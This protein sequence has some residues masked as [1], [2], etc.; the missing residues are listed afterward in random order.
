MLKKSSMSLY[1][2]LFI[3]L[4]A[5][6]FP[7]MAAE[8]KI[9][10]LALRGAN[11]TQSH[12][13]ILADTLNESLP[14]EH[15]TLQP[16]NLDEMRD[17]IAER[18]ID[19]LLTNPAQFI[20]LDSRYHLRWL[21]SLRSSVEPDSATRNVIGSLILVRAD[22]DINEVKNLIGKKVGAISPDAFGGYLLSYKV[23]RDMGYDAEK[24]FRMQFLGFPADALL[25]ALRDSSLSAAII[26][27]CLLENMDSEGL[28]D[29]NQFRPLIEHA[30]T[31]PCKTSTELY[32]NWSFAA[33]N[34]VP[35]N[36]VDK[37]T[38]TLLS[39]D[40]SGMR[41]G[42]P[43]SV[44]QVETLL[45]DVNQHPQ[46]RQIWQDIMSWLIQHQLSLGL[47]LLFFILLGVNHV[48]IAFLVRRRSRQLEEAH[49]RLRQQEA[50][51]EKAQRLNI[52]GEMASGF[53]HELNQP[54]SAIRHYAQGCILRLKKESDDHPLINALTKIDNQA[55]RGA[56]IIRNLRLWAGKPHQEVALQLSE[57][58]VIPTIQHIWQLLR[59]SQHY[60]QVKLMLPDS[61]DVSLKLPE[62][63]LDQL[64]SNLISNS[65]QAG[66]TT[67]CF[68]F[69]FAPE[70]FLLVLQD[71]AGGMQP[72]QLTQGITPF[73]TTK[74]EGLG[75]GLVICQRLIQSQGGDIRIENNVSEAGLNGLR[76]TLIFPYHH[77]KSSET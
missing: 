67:L 5:G 22:S 39:S 23:L 77:G 24:D 10:V 13:Q 2:L 47:V 58:H 57:Q 50:N 73:A 49:N 15:F 54:L 19:F 37:V 32:P 75:L 61:R 72:E 33:L 64:L 38:K 44:N 36:L 52:L 41:W 42:A 4:L 63:L 9:G 29:K 6:S 76:V 35:D 3:L 68:S 27:V 62:T 30:S 70:R 14:G 26:P 48:W 8:W 16:L 31:L 69:H 43:A 40:K 71:D 60:P 65:L 34:D 12:W 59:V 46:Q 7:A 1:R 55:Q 11:S 21:L 66:A 20:Q 17:A 53:A 45:R 51:L 25:Y 56:D 18:K 74:K 28:I